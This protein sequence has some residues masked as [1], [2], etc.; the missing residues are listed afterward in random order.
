MCKPS[1]QT[2]LAKTMTS[3]QPLFTAPIPNIFNMP[4]LQSACLYVAK[5][6]VVHHAVFFISQASQ[7]LA[8]HFNTLQEL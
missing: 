7:G 6:S 5:L 4:T 8:G 1:R 2:C 3:K